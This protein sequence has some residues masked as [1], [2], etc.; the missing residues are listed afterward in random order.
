MT[1]SVLITKAGGTWTVR[2]GGAIIGKSNA[3]LELVENGRDSVIYFPKMVSQWC[4]WTAAPSSAN[5]KREAKPA[6]FQ[7]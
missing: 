6:I 4:F 3:A 2:A 5:A 7:S 1:S